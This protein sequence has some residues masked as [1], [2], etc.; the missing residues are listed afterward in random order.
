MTRLDALRYAGH[1]WTA[2]GLRIAVLYI[3]VVEATLRHG[4]GMVSTVVNTPRGNRR[5]QGSTPCG[6]TSVRL[7]K[8]INTDRDTASDEDGPLADC[9]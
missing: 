3:D 5:D 4:A 2:W 9:D 1:F 7:H 6:S 8:P